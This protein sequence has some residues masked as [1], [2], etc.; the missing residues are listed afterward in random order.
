VISY[1]QQLPVQPP[2]SAP[3]PAA[4]PAPPKPA[5]PAPPKPAE[6]APPKPEPAPPKPKPAP[7]A[8][9]VEGTPLKAPMPGMIVKYEK[10]VGDAVSKGDTVVILEAMK[11]ENALPAPADGT[12]K[13]INF[14][15]GDS[16]GKDEV[17]CVIG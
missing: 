4:A 10:Q 9:D 16:V 3:A 6:P 11:M 15:S 2:V 8:A 12:V 5:E 7:V 17:L 14:S 1:V 13:A